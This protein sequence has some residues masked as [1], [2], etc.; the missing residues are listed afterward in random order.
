MCHVICTPA[1]GGTWSGTTPRRSRW[2]RIR[3]RVRVRVRVKVRVK[4]R[5]RVRVRV[6][7]SG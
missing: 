4:V 2:V 1:C 3:V 7:G 6:L 5:V